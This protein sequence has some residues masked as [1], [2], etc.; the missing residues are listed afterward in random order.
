MNVSAHLLKFLVCV[1]NM[2]NKHDA[3]VIITIGKNS[4]KANKSKPSKQCLRVQ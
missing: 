4:F 3:T 1:F 2:H